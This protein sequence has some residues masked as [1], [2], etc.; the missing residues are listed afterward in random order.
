MLAFVSTE[1]T[2]ESEHA[3]VLLLLMESCLLL[4]NLLDQCLLIHQLWQSFLFVDQLK[5]E[6]LVFFTWVNHLKDLVN[7][8]FESEWSQNTTD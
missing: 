6:A 5:D 3:C 8:H 1:L 4:L 2:S 7:R